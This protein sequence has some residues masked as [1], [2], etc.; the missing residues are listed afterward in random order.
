M[1]GISRGRTEPCKDT[2][3]GIKNVYLWRF[4]KPSF[5]D[6]NVNEGSQLISYPNTIIYKFET[7]ADANSYEE[8]LIEDNAYEQS[9]NIVLK[10]VSSDS[11][12]NVT[13][14]QRNL[15]GVIIE[16]Y[17]GLYRIMGLRN[18]CDVDS[19]NVSTGG[20]KSDY[21]GYKLEISAQEE[22]K[23]PFLSDLSNFY[24]NSGNGYLLDEI[25]NPLT[26]ELQNRLVNA[27]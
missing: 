5:L 25:F 21:N 6:V 11:N 3:G 4:V 12:V 14:L 9:L 15:L 23:A 8:S 18:G 24:I 20:A 16:D 2:L 19:I 27:G 7:V 1:A 13:K 17:N 10:V 26:D 22:Y